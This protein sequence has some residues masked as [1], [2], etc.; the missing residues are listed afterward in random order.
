MKGVGP[1]AIALVAA[2]AFLVISGAVMNT[3]F[4]RIENMAF[5]VKDIYVISEINRFESIKIGLPIAANYSFCQALYDVSKFGGF[6]KPEKSFNGIAIWR[7]YSWTN[8]P[9]YHYN[10]TNKT[11]EFFENYL[12]SIYKG[13]FYYPDYSLIVNE[14]DDFVEINFSSKDLLGYRS[15]ALNLILNQD[16]NV[17]TNFSTLMKKMYSLGKEKF[18]D[19]DS[20]EEAR[21][22]TFE[23]LPE[24]CKIKEMG[25]LCEQDINPEKALPENCPSEESLKNSFVDNINSL[26]G[27]YDGLYLKLN[28]EKALVKRTSDFVYESKEEAKKCGCKLFGNFT[29]VEQT[30]PPAKSSVCVDSDGGKVYNKKGYCADSTGVYSDSGSEKILKEY[31]CNRDFCDYESVDCDSWCKSQGYDDGIYLNGGCSCRKCL[32]WNEFFHGVNYTYSYF[33]AARVLVSI[34]D[35]KNVCPAYDGFTD[36]RNTAL[37]FYTIS[38]NMELIS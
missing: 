14:F 19:K 5:S 31:F 22:K 37:N 2:I 28:V 27:Y 13:Q 11:Y 20:I 29:S 33:A 38:G 17:S 6:I 24:E 15:P 21:E 12:S 23:N 8:F 32:K 7:N 9:N 1:V 4:Y 25:D 3:A 26:S 35:T 30:S 16:P 18:V 36:Y 10:I 34:N